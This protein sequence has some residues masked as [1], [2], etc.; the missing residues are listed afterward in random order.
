MR[1]L[2]LFEGVNRRFRFTLVLSVVYVYRRGGFS[3][4]E[5]SFIGSFLILV[6]REILE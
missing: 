4:V 5:D 2:D 1:E 3:K 6:I